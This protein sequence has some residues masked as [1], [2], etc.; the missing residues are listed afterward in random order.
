MADASSAQSER[1]QL[2]VFPWSDEQVQEVADALAEKLHWLH[3]GVRATELAHAALK[4]AARVMQS[5]TRSDPMGAPRGYGWY[6][7]RGVTGWTTIRPDG[8]WSRG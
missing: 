2:P 7:I 4:A 1:Q 3:D 6:E 5:E 8:T